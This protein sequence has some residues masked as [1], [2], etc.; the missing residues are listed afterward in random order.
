MNE[1]RFTQERRQMVRHQIEARG[2]SDARVLKA[3]L[4]IPRHIFVP[5][6]HRRA[7]Y[8]DGPLPIGHGQ[9]ISQ[10][11]IV[12][13]MTQMLDLRE[14]DHVLEIGAGSGYQAAI[15]SQIAKDV[16]S[17]E[18]LPDIA[19]M[20]RKNLEGRSTGCAPPARGSTRRGGTSRRPCGC[21]GNSDAC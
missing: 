4:S 2:V 5:E 9:T 8:E 16:I 10:P 1:D 13:L 7:A 21:N 15:L 12:G 14:T 3:M 18:R 20:A 19:E 6:P 17:I 11:F